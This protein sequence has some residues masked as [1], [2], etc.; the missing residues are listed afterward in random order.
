MNR[1]AILVAIILLFSSANIIG[2]EGYFQ[3]RGRIYNNTK[4][5]LSDVKIEVFEGNKSIG[6]DKTSQQGVFSL[7]FKLNK[8]YLVEINKAGYV[9]K[10][11][12]VETNVPAEKSSE[13]FDLFSLIILDEPGAE[14]SRTKNGLP[15]SKY[16]YKESAGNFVGEKLGTQTFV[17]NNQA[18][19]ELQRLQAEINQYKA[20][21]EEQQKLLDEARGVVSQADAIKAKAKRYADSVINLAN[22][23]SQSILNF[24]R[25]DSNKIVS[26]ALEKSTKS[27]T[28]DEFEKLAVDE[29]QFQNKKDIQILQ[30]RVNE[31]VK[32][33]N[34]TSRDSIDLKKDRLSLRKELFDLAQYQL[35]IDRLN[36][37]TKEDSMRIE[38]RES[39]LFLMKQDMV[40]AEQELENANNRLIMKDLEIKNKNIMLVSF[41][42]GSLLLLILLGYIYYNYRDKK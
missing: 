12:S 2:Q 7:R 4:D 17:T 5:A 8:I 27:I 33:Q 15:V 34:K 22:R 10:R 25:Q 26:S 38:Q 35:E 16:Y 19:K 41:V 9:P 32:Q 24:A 30:H 20:R 18:S 11:I 1:K 31:L 3:L 13:F 42:I 14:D 23:K 6:T 37:R 21:L 36:V 28:K 40:L 29:K 39:Q